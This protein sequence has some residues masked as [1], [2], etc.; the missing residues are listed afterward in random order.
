LLYYYHY[1]SQ[2]CEAK[3]RQRSTH[4]IIMCIG[5]CS[6]NPK[7]DC[8]ST[9]DAVH[10]VRR[11]LNDEPDEYGQLHVAETPELIEIS[12]EQFDDAVR[13]H[14][15]QCSSSKAC[16]TA[17]L[18]Q[19]R[20]ECPHLLTP[21]FHLQFLRAEVFDVNLAVKRYVKYWEQRRAV[22]GPTRAFLPVAEAMGD[23]DWESIR[24][25]FCRYVGLHPSGRAV[26]L[27]DPSR[28]EGIQYDRES[29]GRSFW[30]MV[31]AAVESTEAQ[32]KGLII[33]WR[34]A[35][36]HMGLFDRK[37]FKQMSKSLQGAFPTRVAALHLCDPP[38][39]LKYVMPVVNM[40]LVERLRRR[41]KFHFGSSNEKILVQLE[42]YGLT[43][44][45]LPTDLGGAKVLRHEEWVKKRHA[46]GL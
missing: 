40:F 35:D 10:A 33:V 13:D 36:F 3:G 31:H 37:L 23:E 25:G 32:K 41:L 28:V 4:T 38:T 1:Y 39:V 7:M 45:I 46:A 29:M 30:Y 17:A 9:A 42:K 24:H 2:G 43:R 12:L 22:F 15:L 14:L 21:E 11:E 27:L 8:G 6:S 34:L 20:K 5:S 44:D 16:S 18:R 19:A 26:V